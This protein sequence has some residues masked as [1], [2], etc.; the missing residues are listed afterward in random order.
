[1]RKFP[2]RSLAEIH[3]E[4]DSR[5]VI[6]GFP[7]PVRADLGFSLWQLQQGEIPAS[8]TRRMASIGAGVWEL[9]EQDE[10]T[11]YRVIYLAKI[12]NVIYV[13]HCFEKQS[14]KTDE[15]DLKMAKQRLAQV[16]QRIQQ[17]RKGT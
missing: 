4:G 2:G 17:R 14:R 15:R 16:R 6:T 8:A 13:L 9:K 10:R 12:D 5:E 7:D 11:W 3:W 1:M